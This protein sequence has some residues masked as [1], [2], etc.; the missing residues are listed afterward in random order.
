MCC[1]G[2][3][4]Q[5]CVWAAPAGAARSARHKII[6]I[7]IFFLCLALCFISEVVIAQYTYGYIHPCQGIPAGALP[8]T[9]QS[10]AD[11]GASL[12]P[13]PFYSQ[14]FS[15]TQ[16]GLA[17]TL[18]G[19]GGCH[20]VTHTTCMLGGG[21]TKKGLFYKGGQNACINCKIET[22]EE[23]MPILCPLE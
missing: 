23:K 2:G 1:R 4:G 9:P 20:I 7:I 19:G 3:G 16:I 21:Y 15:T 14:L 6:I 13:L 8:L 10:L 5:G 11:C 12:T 22:F 17:T 18:G